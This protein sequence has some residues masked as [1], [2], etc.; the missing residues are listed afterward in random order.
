MNI[1]FWHIGKTKESYVVE[2]MAYYFKHIKRYGSFRIRNLNAAA[3]RNIQ[4]HAAYKK[5]EG[6]QIMKAL[7]ST[8]FL[9]LLDERG[10]Q[11]TSEKF[12]SW[13]QKTIDTSPKRIIFL[14]GGAYGYSEEIYARGQCEL[15][16]S[17]MTFPHQLVRILFLEQLYRAFT[18]INH[19]S[20]HH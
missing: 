15:A 14:I 2:G 4:D 12:A 9:V 7:E 20:Y 8:D 10:L 18:I 3:G 19:Q 11:K 13:L 16:L 17:K 1:E 5:Y 6:Q